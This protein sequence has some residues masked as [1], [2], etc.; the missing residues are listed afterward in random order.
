MVQ[1]LFFWY[2]FP[3]SK[4][5]QLQEK[6]HIFCVYCICKRSL[7]L[8]SASFK[9]KIISFVFVA[10]AKDHIFCVCCI[11]KRSLVL[12]SASFKLKIISSVFAASTKGHWC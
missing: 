2:I 9:L 7:M 12:D 10:Y 1:T 4:A 8:D 3:S 11:C 5:I 6:D